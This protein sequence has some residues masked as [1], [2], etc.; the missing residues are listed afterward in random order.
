MASSNYLRLFLV[1]TASISIAVDRVGHKHSQ[2]RRRH[3][4]HRRH[5]Q[6]QRLGAGAGAGASKK[7]PVQPE[8]CMNMCN[9]P[10]GKCASNVALVIKK[11]NATTFMHPYYCKCKPGWV[12]DDC[13]TRTDSLLGWLLSKGKLPFPPCCGVCKAQYDT[14]QDW[15]TMSSD[16]NPFSTDR[17]QRFGWFTKWDDDHGYA[18]ASGPEHHTEE[19]RECYDRFKMKHK[20]FY[21]RQGLRKTPWLD[22][23][24]VREMEGAPVLAYHEYDG[25]EKRMRF[26]ELETHISQ[27][28]EWKK[29]HGVGR[30]GS[31]YESLWL[32]ATHPSTTGDDVVVSFLETQRG[33]ESNP[34]NAHQLQAQPETHAVHRIGVRFDQ[35]PQLWE[36]MMNRFRQTFEKT[37][38][39]KANLETK[40]SFGFFKKSADFPCCVYCSPNA[41]D[42]AGATDN[43]GY[44]KKTGHKIRRTQSQWWKS[45]NILP[46]NLAN[47][48]SH[49][50]CC[51][52]CPGI[53]VGP[54]YYNRSVHEDYE[55]D[56]LYNT[57]NP[58]PSIAFPSLLEEDASVFM[59]TDTSARSFETLETG[60]KA[61]SPFRSTNFKNYKN[62]E[63]MNPHLQRRA[64]VQSRGAGR[65]QNEP[66]G[67]YPLPPWARWRRRYRHSPCLAAERFQ[68]RGSKWQCNV[69]GS[70]CN[71]CPSQFWLNVRNTFPDGP[72]ADEKKYSMDDG[73]WYIEKVEGGL[74][75][76]PRPVAASSIKKK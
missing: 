46:S 67:K 1:L 34:S 22:M 62:F 10:H 48:R 32:H 64:M 14:P 19:E 68:I 24:S 36:G 29:Y 73:G 49:G 52:V 61:I 23:G 6:N 30:I 70:C 54:H 66:K 56:L 47:N 9:P 21:K 59:E 43:G 4:L 13:S 25:K 26:L 7:P 38:K 33:D 76:G 16:L 12:G 60:A 44:D 31:N 15:S 20:A 69:R 74:P 45:P 51:E 75:I 8:Y 58:A 11:P 57:S 18:K 5:G 50:K 65:F 40:T 17:C 2:R 55:N 42:K 72:F 41:T 71:I 27:H 28:P 37:H 3:R 39:N 53:A 35:H 63:K